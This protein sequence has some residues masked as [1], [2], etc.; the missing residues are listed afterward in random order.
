MSFDNDHLL[1]DSEYP[2]KHKA[3]PQA[4]DKKQSEKPNVVP[5]CEKPLTNRPHVKINAQNT[6]SR[7]HR[8]DNEPH[9]LLTPPLTPS[10]SI[11]TTT[12]VDS[13]L[14]HGDNFAI[15]LSTEVAGGDDDL[16]PSRFL[17]VSSLHKFCPFTFLLV[18]GRYPIQL[19]L[20]KRLS[21]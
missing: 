13:S 21:N 12:S 4:S 11:R 18:S 1:L 5:S 9:K 3:P 8:I 19:C 2:K 16:C 6:A 10:S 14:G 17:R 7:K 15:V 20:A